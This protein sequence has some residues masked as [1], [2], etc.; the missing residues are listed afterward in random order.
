MNYMLGAVPA[1]VTTLIADG[2]T[3]MNSA[4]AVGVIALLTYVA[5]RFIR[6]FVK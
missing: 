2:T 6:K 3:V 4:I 5:F 1:D